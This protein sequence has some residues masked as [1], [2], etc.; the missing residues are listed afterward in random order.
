ME[1][2][3]DGRVN[4]K[5][6]ADAAGVATSTVSRV[7]T[8]PEFGSDDTRDRVFRAVRQ[9]GYAHAP[10]VRRDEGVGA[11]GLVL[12]ELDNPFF[13]QL[14]TEVLRVAKRA[15]HSVLLTDPDD[16]ATAGTP[17]ALQLAEQCVGLILWAPAVR[18]AV[19]AELSSRL[20]CVLLNGVDP[21]LPSVSSYGGDAVARAFDYLAGLGHQRFAYVMNTVQGTTSL[22]RRLAA[23]RAAAVQL[24]VELSVIEAH[25]RPD[26]SARYA[27]D[28]VV[29]R[30]VTAVVAQNDR[31]AMSLMRRLSELGV[32]V[33]EQ[34]S[35]IG[36][37]DNPASSLFSPSIT[38]IALPVARL[39]EEAVARVIEGNP[40]PGEEVVLPAHLV[41]REST[42]PARP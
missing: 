15:G 23:A 13:A 10:R 40:V 33:P 30:G 34:V 31:A 5:D 39:A 35:V 22:E 6:V 16:V 12:G 9:L 8:S 36:C 38:T 20:R 28:V 19:V 41:V 1:R 24:G 42:G 7:L 32:G 14:A 18:P 4:I 37:D 3:R 27:A 17:G 25:G 21:G 29:A 11:L 2:G 26:E